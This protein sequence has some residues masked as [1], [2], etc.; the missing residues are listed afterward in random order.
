M[1]Y[2]LTCTKNKSVE[3]SKFCFH[4]LDN[5][6]LKPCHKTFKLVQNGCSRTHLI[7][8]VCLCQ[9]MFVYT[10]TTQGYAYPYTF[11]NS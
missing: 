10:S 7:E 2:I 11:S 6:K 5:N 1:N 9:D 4:V 8:F 3:R